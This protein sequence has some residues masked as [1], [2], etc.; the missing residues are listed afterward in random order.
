MD[1]LRL[2]SVEPVVNDEGVS[3]VNSL[4]DDGEASQTHTTARSVDGARS[5][6]H[7]TCTGEVG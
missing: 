2:D 1:D 6:V 3:F 7:A 4:A 5:P